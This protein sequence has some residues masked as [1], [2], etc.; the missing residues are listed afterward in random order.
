MASSSFRA[1]TETNSATRSLI[2]PRAC[3]DFTDWEKEWI[4]WFRTSL[5]MNTASRRPASLEYSGSSAMRDAAVRMESSSSS[6][7]VAPSYSPLMVRVATRSGSTLSS[8]PDDRSTARTIF[9]TSAASSPPFRLRT[10]MVVDAV[11]SGGAC[12]P[13]VP[14]LSWSVLA[15]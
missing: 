4:S 11:A 8:P 12:C 14:A 9:I 13:G 10:C 2:S 15:K 7:V 6:R 3:P 5:S 1:L